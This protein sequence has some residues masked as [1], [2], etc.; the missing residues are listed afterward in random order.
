MAAYLTLTRRELSAFFL[1]L[2]GYTVIAMAAFLM[3]LSFVSLVSKLQ[4]EPTPM[5]ITEIFYN[6]NYFWFIILFSRR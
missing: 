3:G 2:R 5:P 4:G 6:T 1:A